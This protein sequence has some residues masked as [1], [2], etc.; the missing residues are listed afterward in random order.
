MNRFAGSEYDRQM[1]DFLANLKSPG[2]LKIIPP[3]SLPDLAAEIREALVE[4]LSEVGGHLGGNLGVV[5]LSIALHYVYSSPV[6]KMIWDTGHQ[7]YVHKMLTGR[8]DRMSTI[9]QHGGLAGFA[10]ITES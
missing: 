3:E 2:D 6:D 1:T 5:E 8:R 10:K 9:R 7:S 4:V